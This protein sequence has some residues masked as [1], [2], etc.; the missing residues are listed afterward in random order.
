VFNSYI[1]MEGK[2][3]IVKDMKREKPQT[4]PNREGSAGEVGKKRGLSFGHC[5][6]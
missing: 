5:F 6:L 1:K 4:A 3:V 2:L